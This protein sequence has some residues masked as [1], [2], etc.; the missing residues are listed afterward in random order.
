MGRVFDYVAGI[1]LECAAIAAAPGDAL[2]TT[3]PAL[4]VATEG[5]AWAAINP[6]GDA[7]GT[8]PP[9]LKPARCPRY[10]ATAVSVAVGEFGPS[11]ARVVQAVSLFCA[12]PKD[13]G[14]SFGGGDARQGPAFS[15]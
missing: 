7:T 11:R 12:N 1:Q 4:P 5:R 9:W 15:K 13:A 14:S 10:G 6:P 2:R 3:G 8:Q